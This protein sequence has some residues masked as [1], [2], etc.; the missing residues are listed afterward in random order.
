MEFVKGTGGIVF[1]RYRVFV[2]SVITFWVRK[3]RVEWIM[4]LGLFSFYRFLLF[5][6]WVS[7]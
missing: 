2:G 3:I 4:F 7:E 1:F 6:L 5:I